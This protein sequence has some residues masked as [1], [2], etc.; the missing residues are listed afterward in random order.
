M[1]SARLVVAAC[2]AAT[3]L[4]G[5]KTGRGSLYDKFGVA[6][7]DARIVHF[8][9]SGAGMDHSYVWVIDLADDE[10]IDAIVKSASL[11][12]RKDRSEGSSLRSGFPAWWDTDAIEQLPEGYF[13]DGVRQFWRVWIDRQSNR[14]YAMWFDT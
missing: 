5:C 12:P 7:G 2:V 3:L 1:S 11:S 4:T 8:H 9:F 13:R 6:L 14:I 10:F